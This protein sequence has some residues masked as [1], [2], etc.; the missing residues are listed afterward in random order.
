VE[1]LG[2]AE[3]V[4][5][6]RTTILNGQLLSVGGGASLVKRG[7]GTVILNNVANSFNGP[8]T[9]QT[10]SGAL[11]VDGVLQ[12][13][14]NA[15]VTVQSGGTIGGKGTIDAPVNVQSG[16]ILSPGSNVF[17][18]DVAT[19]TT[20]PLNLAG[21]AVLEFDLSDPDAVGAGVNDL[22]I[23]N[24]DLQLDG[25]LN[26]TDVA[27]FGP[28]LYTLFQFTGGIEDGGLLFGNV[29]LPGEYA[30]A[31]NI[32]PPVAGQ[33]GSVVLGVS[34]V[35]EPSCASALL[36]LGIGLLRRHRN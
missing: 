16:G 14:P 20:G 33:P 4:S 12:N 34:A 10:N 23:V 22:V 25:V 30:Y 35:P 7:R 15:S 6:A 18:F 32:N 36:A 13:Q 17:G 3:L 21:T 27:N 31:V 29:P 9:V 11:L 1:V 2:Q 19:L 26:I 24:G 8:I 5:L 28:G